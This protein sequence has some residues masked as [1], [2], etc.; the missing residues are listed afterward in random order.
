MITEEQSITFA[1][2]IYNDNITNFLKQIPDRSVNSFIIDP[3]YMGV[4][5]D[6]WDNQWKNIEEY[7]SWCE[8]WII[9]LERVSKYSGTIWLFGYSYQL[10]KLIDIFEKHNFT[11]KQQIVIWKGMK[12]AAGRVSNKL[13]QYP[14]TTEY[15][16]MFHYES[17]D[18]TRNKLNKCKNETDLTPTDI[19]KYLGKAFV[20]GGTWSSI[21][22]LKQKTLQSPTK[23]D[24]NKLNTL[25][26]NKLGV[27][28]D[29][30]Y[31]FNLQHGLTDVW[32]DI[33]FYFKP[34]TKFHSTQKPDKLI[35]R[36]V[37]T[38]TNV[39]DIILDPFMGSGSS[40]IN[41]KRLGRKYI[42]ND[43][44]EDYFEIVGKRLE[45]DKF[46]ITKERLEEIKNKGKTK[47]KKNK[48]EL[49]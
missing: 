6:R 10:M 24:W 23:E 47:G 31:T 8:E 5:N 42:G 7:Q 33:D 40:I 49:L 17:K 25:F 15:L 37:E 35:E 43:I 38:A 34:G 22:G 20:G 39:G 4:V 1:N 3:P 32:D 11:Y 16:F 9:E 27:Y 28:E 19:N 45:D 21:A 30:V 41:A 12:S 2:K 48:R 44:D 36:I 14:T 26:N 29:Y 46:S 13:K 18:I